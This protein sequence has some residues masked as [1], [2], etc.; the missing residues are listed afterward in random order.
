MIRAQ[1]PDLT[2]GLSS[3]TEEQKNEAGMKGRDPPEIP[4]SSDISREESQVG[5]T[6]SS[7]GRTNELMAGKTRF[8]FKP[9]ADL[10]FTAS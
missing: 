2:S 8:F 9:G 6:L 10:G 1:I 3:S 4:S 5:Y 7:K